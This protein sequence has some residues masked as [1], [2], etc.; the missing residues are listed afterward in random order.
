MRGKRSRIVNTS[1]V[2]REIWMSKE[3]SRI[4]IA[5]SLQLDKSTIS[6]IVSELIEL[7]VVKETSQGEAGPQGGR[8]PVFL[9]LNRSYG[10]VLGI[11]LRPESYTA[12]AVDLEGSILYS[13]FEL[14]QTSGETFRAVFFDVASRLREELQRLGIPLLGIGLGV[15]GVVDPQRGTIRYSI[16]LRM[17]STFD[18]QAEISEHYDLPLFLENDA[19]ACAWGELAFHRVKNLQDFLFLLVEF[20]DATDRQRLHEKTAVGIGI[21]IGG[22]V[23]YGHTYSAG[24]FRSIL[25]TAESKGQFSLTGEEAVRIEEDGEILSR[26]IRE[27]SSNIAMLVNTFNLSHVFLGGH[28]ERYKREVQ[29]A[30]FEAIQQNWPYPDEVKC[31]IQ[32][33]SLG[34]RAVA[35]GAA[36]MVLHR[37]FTDAEVSRHEHRIRPRGVALL[38]NVPR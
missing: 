24:E 7:G 27:L 35:Y 32:F 2:L 29:S 4:Q 13:K 33:S 16:P 36:G 31:T 25:C 10:C 14:V 28:I 11:E 30:L 5:S 19:N 18:F 9:T 8:K 12:V 37:I 6:S 15:S 38:E 23:H 26:F 17:E 21:V 34:D 1:R 3:I 22:S 20:R